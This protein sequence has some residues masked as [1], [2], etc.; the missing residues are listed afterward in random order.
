MKRNT[1]DII[2]MQ[3]TVEL[4]AAEGEKKLPTFTINAYNGGPLNLA[5]WYSP[6]IVDLKGME[7]PK[8]LAILRDHD[9]RRVVG[10]ADHA[11][12]TNTLQLSG[13]V[14]G[15]GRDAREVT[16]SSLAGFPWQAS[17][18]ARVTKAPEF[19]SEGQTVEVNGMRFRGPVQVARKTRLYETS[20]CVVGADSNTSA[21][22]AARARGF[23]KD[24]NM[25]KF[26]EW[27]KA[28]GLEADGADEVTL[29][30][31]QVIYDADVKASEKAA[32]QETA[33]T[34]E[35]KADAQQDITAEIRADAAKESKRIAAIRKQCTG[36]PDLEAKAI[37]EGW[38]DEKAQLEVLRALRASRP[39]AS[40]FIGRASA[41]APEL[42][43]EAAIR[44][45]SKEPQSRVEADKTYTP[46]ILD[47]ASKMRSL[48]IR[49]LIEQ[50]CRIEGRDTPSLSD[51]PESWIRA[52]FS[53]TGLSGILGDS[54]RKSLSA[55]YSSVA[56]V[57]G[58]IACKL[59]VKDFLTYT[60]YR[61]TGS[62][63]LPK[64]GPGGELKH[65]TVGEESFTYYVETYGELL[66][67][68]RQMLINDDMGA[69]TSIPVME[70]EKAAYTREYLLWTLVRANTGTFFGTGN[71]NYVT[72]API[73]TT[74]YDAATKTLREMVDT[75]SNKMLVNPS[76]VVVPPALE[77]AANRMY[78]SSNLI[79]VGLASTSAKSTEGMAN[80]Y[81]YR[82][83]CTPF[84]AGA[85]T[86]WYLFPDPGSRACF[87][88][89]YLNGQE[90]PTVEDCPL[91]GDLLGQ[92]WRIYCDIGVCQVDKRLGVMARTT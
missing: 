18:G 15:T 54:A 31:W 20:F 4:L 71:S 39:K 24:G 2:A 64:V 26:Q 73:N 56:N 58:E 63:V 33:K 78:A 53:T 67:F 5:G 79:V 68:T 22:V 48:T 9:T 83:L 87:G 27:L 92:A 70:G 62:K 7:I 61:M 43:L 11:K 59:S 34:V 23:G 32:K 29:K 25:D 86:Y 84:L 37:E 91:S 51:S 57:A 55:A 10:H 75:D 17:I 21:T 52:G 88:L 85:D 8:T 66:G 50:C 47:A 36:H 65:S 82:P 45:G 90:G 49:G 12:K 80:T 1:T 28:R 14:S 76:I 69:F 30:A 40:A 46:N 3:G 60:G 42:V 41:G 44:L 74:G 77:A 81:K 13:V 16:A 89:V 6:V 19:I 38:S 35:A 72:A